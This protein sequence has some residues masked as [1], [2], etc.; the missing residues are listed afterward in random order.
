MD[1]REVFKKKRFY[2][3]NETLTS[4]SKFCIEA[5]QPMSYELLV[6]RRECNI[7]SCIVQKRQ[8]F[9]KKIDF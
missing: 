1:E 8:K 5:C 6:Q 7:F 4:M 9:L 3:L 2:D